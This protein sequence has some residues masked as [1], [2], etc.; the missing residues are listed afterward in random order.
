MKKIHAIIYTRVG[1]E[2]NGHSK[3][4]LRQ[5]QLCR[6][7]IYDKD[8]TKSK[9]KQK[10]VGI[11]VGKTKISAGDIILH[12]GKV[13][14]ENDL[15]IL[16]SSKIGVDVKNLYVLNNFYNSSETATPT[17][18]RY[19]GKNFL[20]FYKNPSANYIGGQ[21]FA[22]LYYPKQ[23]QGLSIR[24]YWARDQRSYFIDVE[25]AYNLSIQQECGFLGTTV[26]D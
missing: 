7:Y 17:K 5:L 6:N 23:K 18:V 8:K 9:I 11:K 14:T 1:T 22:T 25:F 13:L 24:K 2:S 26:I 3:N 19:W 15:K 10:L 20:A 12:K 16:L 4:Q 21:N